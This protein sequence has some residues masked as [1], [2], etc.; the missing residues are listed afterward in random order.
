MQAKKTFWEKPYIL[1]ISLQI[2]KLSMALK[3]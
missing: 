1:Q 3:A 2:Y